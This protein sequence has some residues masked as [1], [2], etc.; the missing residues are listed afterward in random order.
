M[1]WVILQTVNTERHQSSHPAGTCTWESFAQPENQH[2]RISSL[3]TPMESMS[4]WSTTATFI[5]YPTTLNYSG[6]HGGQ[7]H[8][9]SQRPVQQWRSCIIFNCLIFKASLPD[10]A[11]LN[12]WN[13]KRTTL[14]RTN[15]PCVIY[16][17]SSYHTL[18]SRKM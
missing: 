16:Y 13:T 9:L 12:R 8:C 2:A 5:H 4:S 6:L 18:H 3:F 14:V 17:L 15:R 1:E 10:S 7:P 11:S